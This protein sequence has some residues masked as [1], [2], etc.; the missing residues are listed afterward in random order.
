MS[1]IQQER[2][3]PIGIQ[4]FSEIRSEGNV[5]VDKT[6]LVYKLV[7]G[8]KFNFLSRPRRFGKSLLQSTI[9]AYFEGRKE[10]FEGLKIAELEDTWEDH[11]VFHID[12]SGEDYTD[13]INV[14][15]ETLNDILVELEEKWGSRPSETQFGRRFAGVIRRACEITGKRVVIL[16]DEYDK[17]LVDTLEKGQEEL[18]AKTSNRLAG[19]YGVLKKADPY[20]RFSLITGITKFSQLNI[21]SGLNQ[22]DDI[23]LNK[24]YASICGL[25]Q[26]ELE[27]NFK[28]EI[29]QLADS[30]GLSHEGTLQKLKKE[31][32]G[33]RFS[34]AEVTVYNPFSTI[35]V[36][37]VSEFNDYWF[38]T[39]TPTVLIKEIG[40]IEYD[41]SK[42]DD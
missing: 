9:K 35:K 32:N 33:Y 41:I 13:D 15:E 16:I 40:R 7:K 4:T 30:N 39:S 20:I 25:T 28:P 42:F 19:F 11:P 22:L 38:E 21:F 27:S 24:N 12:L 18:H 31:Y 34:K 3:M 36:L 29:E 6:D 5:Y 37:K 10:L 26:A 1:N 8:S 2:K 23:T 17:P 14:L